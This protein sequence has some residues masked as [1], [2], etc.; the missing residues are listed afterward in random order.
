MVI[1]GV[2]VNSSFPHELLRS[3]RPEIIFCLFLTVFPV[4][5]KS[6][7]TYKPFNTYLNKRGRCHF[8]HMSSSLIEDLLTCPVSHLCCAT[9]PGSLRGGMNTITHAWT[10]EVRAAGRGSSG[11]GERPRWGL[12]ALSP[13]G[14]LLNLVSGFLQVNLFWRL[15]H[16]SF[17]KCNNTISVTS[18]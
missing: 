13:L 10:A 2:I 9:W 1:I 7:R 6:P 12:G 16:V 17:I 5:R 15:S 3:C 4:P 18:S 11:S 8:Y 14:S